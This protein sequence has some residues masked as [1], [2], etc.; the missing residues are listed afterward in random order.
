[1]IRRERAGS[2]RAITSRWRLWHSGRDREWEHDRRTDRTGGCGPRVSSRRARWRH[3]LGDLGRILSNAKPA[4]A[5]REVRVGD[6]LQV[7]N[8]GG[9]YEVEVLLL[10][11]TRGPAPVAQTLYRETERTGSCG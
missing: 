11:E 6:V 10:S 4:K 2:R 3:R 9:E 7:K 5:A 1:V 8:A